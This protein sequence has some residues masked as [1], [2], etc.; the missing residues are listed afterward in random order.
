MTRLCEKQQPWRILS[1]F[2][3]SQE[4]RSVENQGLLGRFLPCW[5][6]SKI[7]DRPYQEFDISQ[8]A[9][10]QAYRA[11][12]N[13]LLLEPLPIAD[14]IPG[15]LRPPVMPCTS[16]AKALWIRFYNSV[17]KDAKKGGV[18]FPIQPFACKA[19]EH[20]LR[21]AGILAAVACERNISTHTM[22]S[23]IALMNWYSHEWLRIRRMC[24][25]E[26]DNS[27]AVNLLNWLK[28]KQ[29]TLFTVQDIYQGGPTSL[30]SA[31]KAKRAI[32]ELE[33]RH[34]VRISTFDR[35]GASVKG[36]EVRQDV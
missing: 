28:E 25:V 4:G 10:Y 9:G 32:D 16:D 18:L 36:F 5:P 30:R 22:A 17:E 29:K 19:A 2:T 7:G 24:N 3:K 14:D 13:T 23:A 12:M 11:R 15:E 33:S 20:A 34:F 26:N 21:L 6:K 1:F 31:S 35:L 8:D 27:D